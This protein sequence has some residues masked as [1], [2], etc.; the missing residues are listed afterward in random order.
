MMSH[1][2]SEIDF[3]SVFL[4]THERIPIRFPQIAKSLPIF[5]L[6]QKEVMI[7]YLTYILPIEDEFAVG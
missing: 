7:V 3:L 1:N 2:Q 5:I 6:Q 4:T